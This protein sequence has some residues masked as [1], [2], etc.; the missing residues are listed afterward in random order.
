MYYTIHLTMESKSSYKNP[1][2]FMQLFCKI[3]IIGVFNCILLAY[4]PD[5]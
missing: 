3:I 2:Y 4:L 5:L 1:F